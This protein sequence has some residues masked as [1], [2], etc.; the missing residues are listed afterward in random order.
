MTL[1]PQTIAAIGD[2][3]DIR[4]WS[5]IPFSFWQ[6]AVRHG[7]D[8]APARLDLG[9]FQ[10]RRR[11]WNAG[12]LLTSGCWG[13]YQYSPEFLGAAEQMM[14]PVFRNRTVLSFHH[15]FP[16]AETIRRWGG[17]MIYY[18]D[19][20]LAAEL[21]GHA[22][23]LRL[24]HQQDEALATERANLHGAERIFTMARWLKDYLVQTQGIAAEK[25]EVV[26]PGAN[27]TV[28]ADWQHVDR[29][30]ERPFVLGLVGADWKRKGLEMVQQVAARMQAAGV[31]TKV[32]IIGAD[33]PASEQL[34]THG[35]IDKRNDSRGFCDLLASCD[36]GCLFSSHEAFGISLLEFLCLGV[37]VAGWRREGMADTIPPDAGFCFAPDTSQQQVADILVAYAR[38]EARQTEFRYNARRWAPLLSWDRCV[39]EMETLLGGG[40]VVNPVQPWRGLPAAEPVIL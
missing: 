28:P 29:S 22:L 8:V 31:P 2:V 6:A 30:S 36:L 37:P 13:G 12:H 1:R 18:L 39:G 5:G 33:L 9:P 32:R 26:T 34:E 21:D 35:F 27:V 38:D 19:A 40:T 3:G 23:P 17:R 10:A 11:W 16:R 20:T 15:H 4:T 14:E 24:R 7:W 25:I